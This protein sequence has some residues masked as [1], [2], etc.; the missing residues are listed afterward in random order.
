MSSAEQLTRTPP[1]PGSAVPAPVPAA[2]TPLAWLR[3]RLPAVRFGPQHLALAGVLAFSAVLNTNR[4]SQ[5]GYA[6]IYYSAG[7]KSMLRSLHNF[8]FVSFDP[9][10]LI[11]VD[12]PPLGLWLQA[13]SAK[14]FGFSPLSVLLPEAIMGVLAVALLYHIVARRFGWA[15]GIASALALA[16]F[17]S[18]VA[19]SRDSGVDPL[20]I[21]LMLLACGAAVRAAET[22]RWRTLIWCAVLVGLAFN[23]K[24]LA[25][26]LVVPGIALAYLICAP[27]SLPRRATQLAVAGLVLIAVSFSWMAVVELTPA[28]QRPFVGSSTNNTE[29]GLTFEYNGLGRV[30]GQVGG[31]GQIP[32]GQGALA[33]YHL[34]ETPQEKAFAL[35]AKAGQPAA[36]K[37][38]SAAPAKAAP[39]PHRASQP[40]SFPGPTGPLRLFGRGLGDQGG[41]IVPLAFFG[42]IAIALLLLA[43]WRRRP[44]GR[45]APPDREELTAASPPAAGAQA[46]AEASSNT[47]VADASAP[48]G[49]PTPGERPVAADPPAGAAR[50]APAAGAVASVPSGTAATGLRDPR[51]ATTLVLGGWFLVEAIVLSFSHGIVHPYYASALA[52]GAAAMAGAGALAFVQ[53]ARARQLNWRILAMV[54]IGGAVA[55]TVWAQIVILHK[56]SYMHWFVPVLLICSAAGA[57][58]LVL[59][60]RMAPA[61]MALIFC[62]L[63]VAPAAYA[64][65]T[66]LAPVEGTFPAAGP[67]QAAGTGGVGISPAHVRAVRALLTYVTTHGAGSRW[68]LFTDAANTASPMILLGYDAGSLA[69][70]SGIDPTLDGRGLARLV[71]RREARYVVLGGVFSSRGGNRAT[72]AVLRACAQVPAPAWHGP[73][74]PPFGLVPYDCGGHERALASR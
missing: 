23:T 43:D 74:V 37:K 57:T 42:M 26:Y 30:Q 58:V 11:T 6:N 16:V 46:A 53:L 25:A 14:V 47:S 72:A 28:S 34:A 64:S 7:V 17:P 68:V 10:G 52:P 18:F 73:A 12:K 67:T 9:H 62:L 45:P 59:W 36:S 3:A 33:R 54:V 2:P 49:G 27:G 4:L 29:L 66:W 38:L 48:A 31:P 61:A 44:S 39:H 65:T 13:A 1:A 70:Y 60:R 63:L 8:F 22:G 50:R 69:G 24:T 51:L 56:Q 5:N 41:W 19:V 35:A 55:G 71:S 40:V 32:H 20:M 21:L 15:A